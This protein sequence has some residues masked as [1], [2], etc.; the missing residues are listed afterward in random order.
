MIVQLSRWSEAISVSALACLLSSAADTCVD[1]LAA[2]RVAGFLVKMLAW[3][4]ETPV[5][6]WIVLGVLKRDNLV[7]KVP[8]ALPEWMKNSASNRPL[9]QIVQCM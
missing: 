7:Y 5:L 4:L 1:R 9:L 3:V 8:A 6:G 2:P